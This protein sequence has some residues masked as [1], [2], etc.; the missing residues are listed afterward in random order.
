MS[1]ATRKLYT[2]ASRPGERAL[3]V[4]SPQL[5]GQAGALR[6]GAGD[7]RTSEQKEEPFRFPEGTEF[8]RSLSWCLHQVGT[9]KSSQ[10]GRR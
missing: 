7:P 2:W 1:G 8:L 6:A 5:P 10:R 4:S 3:R 9:P